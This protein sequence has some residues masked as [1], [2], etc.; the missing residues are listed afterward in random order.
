[1]RVKPLAWDHTAIGRDRIRAQ[2]HRALSYYCMLSFDHPICALQDEEECP[3]DVE[4]LAGRRTERR[5]E[6]S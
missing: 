3:R 4:C 5:H 2:K 6:C 1:M